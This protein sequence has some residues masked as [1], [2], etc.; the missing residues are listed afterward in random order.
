MKKNRMTFE[1][2]IN[3]V[4]DY[5]N[6]TKFAN[7][8]CP[9]NPASA[10]YWYELS[11]PFD[12]KN[13]KYSAMLEA[14]H[15]L[16]HANQDS[17]KRKVRTTQVNGLPWILY[18]AEECKTPSPESHRYAKFN[19]RNVNCIA[20]I[21]T[22]LM[23]KLSG[24]QATHANT[25]TLYRMAYEYILGDKDKTVLSIAS[26]ACP[27]GFMSVFYEMIDGI[28]SAE[29]NDLMTNFVSHGYW[30]NSNDTDEKLLHY[31]NVG[32]LAAFHHFFFDV[33]GFGYP[34]SLVCCTTTGHYGYEGKQ[35]QSIFSW[36]PSC[37][38]FEEHGHHTYRWIS[39]IF[40]H[41]MRILSEHSHRCLDSL[42]YSNCMLKLTAVGTKAIRSLIASNPHVVYEAASMMASMV[43]NFIIDARKYM[44]IS[45]AKKKNIVHFAT[46]KANSQFDNTFEFNAHGS[47]LAIN[48]IIRTEGFREDAMPSVRHRKSVKACSHTTVDL[49]PRLISARVAYDKLDLHVS[50]KIHHYDTS[51]RKYGGKQERNFAYEWN[52]TRL[53]GTKLFINYE[54]NTIGR[55]AS[56]VKSTINDYGYVP[57]VMEQNSFSSDIRNKSRC[58]IPDDIKRNI[59]FTELPYLS[60]VKDSLRSVK[61]R[62]ADKR[63]MSKKDY[64]SRKSNYTSRMFSS[65]PHF[66]EGSFSLSHDYLSSVFATGLSWCAGIVTRVLSTPRKITEAVEVLDVC[67][68]ENARCSNNWDWNY[69]EDKSKGGRLATFDWFMR[70]YQKQ[71]NVP[72]TVL[73]NPNT[74]FSIAFDIENHKPKVGLGK[75]SQCTA[76]VPDYIVK[77]FVEIQDTIKIIQSAGMFSGFDPAK[78]W[79][80]REGVY[81]APLDI[82]F[83]NDKFFDPTLYSAFCEHTDNSDISPDM[84]NL[85][86]K[87][88][89]DFAKN[90]D[91]RVCTAYDL[92]LILCHILSPLNMNHIINMTNVMTVPQTHFLNTKDAGRLPS[93]TAMLITTSGERVFPTPH[94]SLVTNT[95]DTSSPQ[96]VMYIY[97]L[98]ACASPDGSGVKLY[99]I[100][101]INMV[102]NVDFEYRSRGKEQEL[103]SLAMQAS[104]ARKS[105]SLS[106][107]ISKTLQESFSEF[108]I[109]DIDYIDS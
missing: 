46:L 49:A 60:K 94:G 102:R 48:A 89:S 90:T 27:Y 19:R 76:E 52:N 85:A 22:H 45:V 53:P 50:S 66:D 84:L 26:S 10:K 14:K 39:H 30:Y 21:A 93:A 80:R 15:P 41:N 71:K 54:A 3:T 8:Y 24:D 92:H 32:R 13:G 29:S 58:N 33:F 72:R 108:A 1:D 100:P 4:H 96:G 25:K 38:S 88:I 97:D 109:N 73:R 99:Q 65:L 106:E 67:R 63:R 31:H 81:N 42:R 55:I 64:D 6:N 12:H 44:P 20:M 7:G 98:Y 68:I 91:D 43:A 87:A 9:S 107:N 75:P 56:L 57:Y 16:L 95:I 69:R 103:R 61:E 36:V 83:V 11:Q 17:I 105:F 74:G 23:A 34:F 2:A 62:E 104:D 47:D 28:N 5:V 40:R 51:M 82:K 77:Q 79:L 37:D 86:R 35:L 101:D 18:G 78:P 70:D 59:L